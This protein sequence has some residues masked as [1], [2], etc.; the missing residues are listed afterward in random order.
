MMVI[1]KLVQHNV[2]QTVQQILEPSKLGVAAPR[3]T[4]FRGV[5]LGT[6]FVLSQN[7]HGIQQT[8]PHTRGAF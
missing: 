2:Q 3:L 7:W 5:V 6:G 1:E 4:S 8:V